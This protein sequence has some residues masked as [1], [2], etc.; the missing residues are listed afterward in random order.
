MLRGC[1]GGADVDGAGVVLEKREIVV[2][3]S[4]SFRFFFPPSS[5]A[6]ASRREVLAA[7]SPSYLRRL[8]EINLISASLPILV[9]YAAKTETAED[10]L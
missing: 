10:G 6:P 4:I 1:F 3:L 9:K 8:G 2:Y 7:H 5:K